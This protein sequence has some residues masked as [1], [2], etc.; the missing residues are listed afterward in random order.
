MSERNKILDKAKKLKE[1]ADRGIGG[2]KDNAKVMLEKWMLKHNITMNEL[3]GHTINDTVYGNM[4]DEQLKNYPVLKY[5]LYFSEFTQKL[6]D[7]YFKNLNSLILIL[8]K[9]KEN[10]IINNE[11][12]NIIS[13][14]TKKIIDEMYNLCH[15]YYVYAIISLI[16]ADVTEQ[17]IEKIDKL[18]SVVSKALVK[19][20]S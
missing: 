11:T 19:N 13:D 8:E 9:I 17:R 20:S 18:S 16:N 12:L 3:E 1:L 6:K 4:T 10:S 14:E 7:N 5:N 15:Y 2:E